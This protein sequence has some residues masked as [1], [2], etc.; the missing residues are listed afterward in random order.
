MII[1]PSFSSLILFKLYRSPIYSGFW[2]ER[3]SDK[4]DGLIVG[5]LGAKMVTSDWQLTRLDICCYVAS[6]FVCCCCYF[7][8]G[9]RLVGFRC[10]Q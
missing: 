6:L 10:K 3:V 7:D 1:K 4:R 2:L 5:G 9:V 8:F